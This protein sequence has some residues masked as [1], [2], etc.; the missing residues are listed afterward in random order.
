VSPRQFRWLGVTLAVLA[1]AGSYF[2]W[3]VMPGI[4]PWLFPVIAAVG[5]AVVTGVFVSTLVRAVR[6]RRRGRPPRLLPVVVA[7]A[8]F[9]LFAVLPSVRAVHLLR[10]A[11]VGAPRI[12]SGF[13]DWLGAE[14]Y[15]RINGRHGGLDVAGR[16]GTPVLAAAGGRVRVARDNADSC[17]LTIVLQHD[18]DAYRTI[19]CHLSAV[20]VTRGD[21]VRRGQPIGA[22]GMSGR[23]PWPRYE[24]VHLEL[25]NG[26]PGVREDPLTKTVGR[27]DATR[28]YP[29]DR[30]LLAYPVAC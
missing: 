5:A 11:S 24:H 29:A 28:T 12:L 8:A 18:V 16:F 13:G 19:Y 17:G 4:V 9:V 25:R 20:S 7:T 27:F 6:A 30:L 14:G 2:G 21:A 10:P 22:I 15:V 26:M 23:R 3:I 1:V